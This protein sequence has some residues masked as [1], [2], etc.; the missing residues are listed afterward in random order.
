MNLFIND[1]P[2][3]LVRSSERPN[4]SEFNNII[5]AE[6]EPITQAKLLHRVWIKHAKRE[7]LDQLFDLLDTTVPQ[8][9][10]SITLT[11]DDYDDM[12][13]FL[14][15]KF[16]VIKAAGGLVRK[17]DKILMIYRLKKWDLPKG[18]LDKG[19]SIREAAVREVQEECNVKVELN[20]KICTTWHTYTMKKRR[21]LKKTSW[22]TMDI[23]KD[24]KMKPQTEEDIEEVRWMTR[25][26]VFHALQDSYKS[27]GFVFDCYFKKEK[28]AEE[29]KL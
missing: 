16:K 17:K 24:S 20:D 6:I 28:Q 21:I 18:K 27:I 3:Q 22:Y 19:E 25:K 10:I 12:K 26:E 13:K 1:I 15:K 14:K 4:K 7:D 8:G 29:A 11:I 9:L 2:V 23:V 5:N